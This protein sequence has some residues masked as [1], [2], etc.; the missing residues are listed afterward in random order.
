MAQDR[1]RLPEELE[2]YF[3]A[4]KRDR[5]LFLQPV[6][7]RVERKS[8]CNYTFMRNREIDNKRQRMLDLLKHVMQTDHCTD[9]ANQIKMLVHPDEYYIYKDILKH[10]QFNPCELAVSPEIYIAPYIVFKSVFRGKTRV[11]RAHQ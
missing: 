6:D 11:T 7:N 2:D 4:Y 1:L 9:G 3:E 5:D 10:Y 8:I